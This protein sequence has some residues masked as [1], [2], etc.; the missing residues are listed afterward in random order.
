MPRTFFSPATPGAITDRKP[1]VDVDTIVIHTMQGTFLGSIAT[2]QYP[3]R[4]VLTA[5]HYLTSRAGDICQMV[6]DEK[7]CAHANAY[8]SRSIGIEHEVYI[9]SW[10]VRLR[11][12]GTVKPPP[13][14]A[15]EFP[16][17]ML[18]AS[19]SIAAAMCK[20]FHIPVDRQHILGHNEVPGA[21]HTD[22][23][24]LFPWDPYL[25]KVRAALAALG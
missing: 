6:P 16:D 19:A 23:G 18:N 22:P 17:P 3:A 2:F 24:P 10:P 7:K 9:G 11:P 12:D 13:F 4:P 5:A 25:A 8:N 15:N 20:K 21:T 14:P 1:G